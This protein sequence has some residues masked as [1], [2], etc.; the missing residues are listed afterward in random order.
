MPAKYGGFC[1]Q[2]GR[3]FGSLKKSFSLA[4]GSDIKTRSE[5]CDRALNGAVNFIEVFRMTTTMLAVQGHV[6]SKS[7]MPK[8][9]LPETHKKAKGSSGSIVGRF[10]IV[11][12]SEIWWLFPKI[13]SHSSSRS[14]SRLL[15]HKVLFIKV[16]GA[17]TD[18]AQAASWF[19]NVWNEVP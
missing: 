18:R 16:K 11:R 6:T 7:K 13:R 19:F 2:L 3:K 12:I 1:D 4:F 10:I 5:F 14:A 9:F 8:T 15:Y 17:P